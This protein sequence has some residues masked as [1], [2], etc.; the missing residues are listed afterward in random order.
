[1]ATH[2]KKIYLA[3]SAF[4]AFID[5]AHPRYNQASA[6]FRYFAQEQYRLYTDSLITY[7]VHREL[8]LNI[9]PS[10]SRDFLRTIS[11]S[12]INIFYPDEAEMRAALK[13]LI[14]Y[15]SID[16]TFEK[17]LSAVL[18]DKHGISQ[19]CTFE[20]LHNLFGLS[21]FYLPL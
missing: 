1:M 9:S 15:P 12:N 19:I 5:R 10:L 2:S 17:A 7:E 21:T 8:Y 4:L 11:F 13:T 3:P 20:Y 14:N 18:A 16:L 6:F